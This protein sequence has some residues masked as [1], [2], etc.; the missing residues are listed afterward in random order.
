MEA[1]EVFGFEGPLLDIIQRTDLTQVAVMTI[2]PDGDSGPADPNEQSDQVILIL[3][4]KARVKVG[5]E[6]KTFGP[7]TSVLVPAGVNSRVQNAGDKP[8]FLYVVT[9]TAVA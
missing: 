4:G 2:P 9:A 8:L 1:V 3:R 7:G 6:E 5:D